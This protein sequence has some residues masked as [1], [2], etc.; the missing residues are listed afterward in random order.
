MGRYIQGPTKGKAAFLIDEH[1]ATAL[2][3]PLS[4]E[5]IPADKALICV[6]YGTHFDAAGWAFDERELEEFT[7]PDTRPKTWLLMD[8]RL[9]ERLTGYAA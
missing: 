1:S 3:G 9:V 7:R 8:K 6:V 2:T 5:H 4:W